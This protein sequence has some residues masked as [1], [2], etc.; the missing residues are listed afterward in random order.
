[1]NAAPR[2]GCPLKQLRAARATTS[3]ERASTCQV[4]Q[5]FMMK[6]KKAKLT[7]KDVKNEGCSQDLIENR[8]QKYTNYH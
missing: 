4:Y 8:G 7:Q 5:D 3:F 6:I 1:M 2:T